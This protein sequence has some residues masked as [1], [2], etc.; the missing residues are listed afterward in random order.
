MN[1]TLEQARKLKS[2]RILLLIG[3]VLGPL[4]TIFSDGFGS[5]H[6]YINTMIIGVIV[7]LTVALFEFLVFTGKI[8]KRPFYQLFLARILLYAASI[9]A[10]ILLV[11]IFSRML[12]YDMSFRSVYKSAEFQAYLREGDFVVGQLFTLGVVILVIF[13]MQMGRKISPEVL[14]G[15]VSGAY[16]KPRKVKRIVMFLE[17]Q[18]VKTIIAKIGRVA[19]FQ[20]LNDLI[21]DITDTILFRKGQ[22]YEYVEDEILLIWNLHKGKEQANCIRVYFDIQDAIEAK[23]ITYFETYGFVPS[24]HASLHYGSVII[25]EI[26]DIKSELRYHGD[27]M[28]TTARILGATTAKHKFLVSAALLQEIELPLIYQQETLGAFLLKGKE[29]TVEIFS[30]SENGKLIH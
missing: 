18:D 29:K 27:V 10:T 30:L 6:P 16:A 25:G 22:I 26:G 13:T 21:F 2:T 15:F 19:F 23:K 17:L 1:L 9:N 5:I 4:Y 12:R 14:L 8:R 7:A 11:M 28:N 20:F 24:F 3:V